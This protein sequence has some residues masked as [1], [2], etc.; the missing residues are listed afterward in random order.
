MSLS[1]SRSLF[2]LG[3][4]ACLGLMGAALYLEHIVGLE[5]CPLCVVQRVCVMV[6]GLIFLAAF[7]HNPNTLGRRIYAVLGAVAACVGIATAARQV[8]LQSLPPDQLPDS[9]MAM[10]MDYIMEYLPLAD[11]LRVM[12]TGTADCAEVTWTLLGLSLPE[13]SLLGFCAMAVLSILVL[14]KHR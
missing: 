13:W 8:W 7:I 5:P 14:I 11:M 2:L 12:F 6:F 9:C 1:N 4:V 10:S 3:I